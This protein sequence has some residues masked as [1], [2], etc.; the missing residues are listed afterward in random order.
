[1]KD[2]KRQMTVRLVNDASSISLSVSLG[3]GELAREAQHSGLTIWID[4]DG[5][6]ER[7]F[8]IHLPGMRSPFPGMPPFRDD[9][10]TDHS[11]PPDLPMDSGKVPEK[12][13]ESI[14]ITY[15]DTTGPLKMDMDEVRKTGLDI[16]VGKGRD[17][18][19][20]Y[21]F[22]ISFEA[23]SCLAD[24][25]PGSIIGIAVQSGGG[26]ADG[27]KPPSLGTPGGGMGGP[28]PGGGP[29]GSGGPGGGS[30]KA[31]EI[32]LRVTLGTDPM[33]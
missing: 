29:G 17:G 19:W 32:W 4:P 16:G 25:G 1:M 20:I 33:A 24:L 6:K 14:F 18:R 13:L 22:A 2:A 9:M 31:F 28:G 3:D 12:P 8:G 27:G 10:K 30:S 15:A 7:V 11:N 26:E 5:G 21:E 23:D